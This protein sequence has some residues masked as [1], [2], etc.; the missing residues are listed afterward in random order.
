MNPSI[1]LTTR[2]KSRQKE[3]DTLSQDTLESVPNEGGKLSLQFKKWIT[4]EDL[5]VGWAN[6]FYYFLPFTTNVLFPQNEEQAYRKLKNEIRNLLKNPKISK[7]EV[8]KFLSNW[9]EEQVLRLE[10][11]LK[12]LNSIE[13]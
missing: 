8:L 3:N 6:P 10:S 11:E 2:K 5:N 9:R 13:Q 1:R 4:E 7:D 12:R